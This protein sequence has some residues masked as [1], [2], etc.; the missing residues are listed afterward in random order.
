MSTVRSRVGVSALCG[1]LFALGG[2]NGTE[3]LST[4]EAYDPQMTKW[5]TV[6][7]MSRKRS[8]VGACALGNHVYVC[9]GYDGYTSL[10]TVGKNKY[11]INNTALRF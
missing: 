3:R 4:V 5:T 11:T 10:H 6:S 9:G 2:Y 8:A 1:R 7:P